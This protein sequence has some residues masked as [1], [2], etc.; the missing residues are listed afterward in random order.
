[1][2]I[3]HFSG[4]YRKAD[5]TDVSGIPGNVERPNYPIHPIYHL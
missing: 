1:M 3:L 4:I 5:F 2:R